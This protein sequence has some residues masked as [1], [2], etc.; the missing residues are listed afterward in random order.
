MYKKS[1][2]GQSGFL[3]LSQI[4]STWTV[5]L[6]AKASCTSVYLD[7]ARVSFWLMDPLALI[8]LYEGR[9]KPRAHRNWLNGLGCQLTKGD[10]F[11]VSFL[12]LI[13]EVNGGTTSSG[14]GRDRSS[15]KMPEVPLSCQGGCMV[16]VT[17]I[18]HDSALLWSSELFR[19][20]DAKRLNMINQKRQ[21]LLLDLT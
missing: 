13:Q 15:S 3:L 7:F 20:G 11:W 18:L 8:Y 6:I 4:L 1:C 10:L 2:S 5:H 17:L 21:V 19:A 9:L 16:Q 14:D 12:D